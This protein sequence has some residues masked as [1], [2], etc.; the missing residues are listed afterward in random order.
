M[1]DQPP[2]LIDGAGDDELQ[3][4]E[5]A[6]AALRRLPHVRSD[7][8]DRIV[9]A[10]L[11]DERARRRRPAVWLARAAMITLAAGLGAAGMWYGR[12]NE[13]PVAV[14]R[15]ATDSARA[16]STNA[17]P[18]QFASTAAGDEAPVA[19]PFA[20]RRPDARRVALVGDFDEW[21]PT[22]VPMTRDPDG[23]WTTTVPLTP[24]RHAYAFVVDDSVWTTDP[25]APLERDP[26]YGRSHSI[27][28]VGRP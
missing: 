8:A 9:A 6:T 18:A 15:V 3:G 20:L 27:V 16:A 28:V 2:V 26:D 13:A 5:R 25:R 14:Q 10:A 21:S 23:T 22:A 24:G 1:S 12:A 11:A 4:L 7:A 19:T 17:G